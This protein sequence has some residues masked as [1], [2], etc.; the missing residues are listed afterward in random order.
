VTTVKPKELALLVKNKVDR[1]F[2]EEEWNTYVDQS[3]NQ[4]SLKEREA[5]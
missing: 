3:I 5:L 2:T 4:E 1:E